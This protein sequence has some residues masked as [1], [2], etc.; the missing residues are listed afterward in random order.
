[1]MEYLQSLNNPIAIV[2]LVASIVVLISMCFNTKTITGELLMRS[3]NLIGS[4][5]SVVYGVMLGA[6]GVGMIL[7]NG[8]L[9]FVNLYYLVKS[10]K[11]I[12]NKNNK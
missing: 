8:T 3:L 10:L 4:I 1:M 12:K 2:G 9:I 7:L 11:N 5:I 6:L